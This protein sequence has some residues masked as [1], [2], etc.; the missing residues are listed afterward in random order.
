L[1]AF[2]DVDD[3]VLQSIERIKRSPFLVHTDAIRGFVFEVE[4]GKLREV[5]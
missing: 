1:E 3:D 2:S 5:K 4:T